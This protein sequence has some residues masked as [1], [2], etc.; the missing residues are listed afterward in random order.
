MKSLALAFAFAPLL[1]AA[2][3]SVAAADGKCPASWELWV[4]PPDFP[5]DENA[6][7]IVCAKYRY[8]GPNAEVTVYIRDDR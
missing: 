6:N 4:V 8:N 3:T 1:L 5:A 2:P 7:G